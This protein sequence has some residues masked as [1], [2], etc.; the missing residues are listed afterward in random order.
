MIFVLLNFTL[1]LSLICESVE[2]RG[3]TCKPGG[4]SKFVGMPREESDSSPLLPENRKK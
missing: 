4:T 3:I 2:L 1:L